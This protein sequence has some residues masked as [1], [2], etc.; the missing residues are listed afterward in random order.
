MRFVE[1]ELEY[2]DFSGVVRVL[3]G[4]NTLWETCRGFASLE[5]GVP[6]TMD[7]RFSVASVTKQFTAFAVL[8]LW[9]RGLLALEKDANRYLPPELCLPEGITV[10]HLLCHTSGLHNF[11]NFE[12][13]F[14][15][16]Q[17]RLPY[18]RKRF[19]DRWINRQDR[20]PGEEFQYN[21]SNYNLLAWVIEEVSG[22]SYGEFL[23]Q[24]VFEPLGMHRTEL[25]DGL[26]VL[27]N[28]ACCYMHDWGKTVRV[29]YANP[30]FSIGAGGLV[31]C[32]DDLQRWY[33]ALRDRRLL[34]GAG[35]ERFFTEN[36]EH[37]C[38]GLERH[39][40]DGAVKYSH[41]GDMNG[42][43]AYVQYFFEEDLCI[44]ILSN[45]E[46]LNQYRLG[47]AIAEILHGGNPT[48]EKREEEISLPEEEL[49]RFSGTYLPGKIHVRVRDGRL[50]LV[51][52][53]QNIHIELCCVG[54]G[55]FKRR[56]EESGVLLRGEGT[57]TA[58]GYRQMSREFL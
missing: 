20:A 57:P 30:L 21:N 25:D 48:H 9:D 41:G 6:N 33:E 34:S 11:Y 10:H 15:V 22:Q 12:D 40:R 3:Q 36:R 51:R 17:D 42:V 26:A 35:Y 47:D 29:P 38:Y 39:V 49:E 27:P 54:P 45:N 14:Y 8:L 5:F 32:C 16:F 13:D 46:S 18:D 43:A 31:T 50:F 19:F 7:T 28:K 52:M 56:W 23:R 24:N 2:W 55:L 37:Y 53:N 58:W 44:L 4:G 1:E